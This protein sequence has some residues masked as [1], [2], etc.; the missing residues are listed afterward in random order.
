MNLGEAMF[1]VLRNKG[2][3]LIQDFWKED[4][5]TLF[6]DVITDG[7]R[8]FRESREKIS[9]TS[10]KSLPGNI[11]QT[12]SEILHIARYLP[13]RI[14][15]GLTVFQKDMV[16]QL[17]NKA[18]SREK[19]LFSL[20]VLGILTSSTAGTFYNL[21]SPGKGLSLGKVRIRSA[22]AQYLIAEFAL[23]SLRLFLRRFL[24]E[25]EKEVTAAEDLDHVRYFKR[26]MDSEEGP[27][28][29]P[30]P[31]SDDQAFVITERLR[32]NILNGDDES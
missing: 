31:S 14:R 22:L 23:K 9:K 25:L 28:G 19:A 21:R 18:D 15:K 27:Q 17:G 29:M 13:G 2:P 10:L 3:N 1:S 12:S 4:V 11:V 24:A 5:A 26:L 7:A 32:N 20:R 30:D 8:T 6:G 16:S